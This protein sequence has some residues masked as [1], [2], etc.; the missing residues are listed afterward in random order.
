MD[1]SSSE[2]YSDEEVEAFTQCHLH[3]LLQG[4]QEVRVGSLLPR[5]TGCR[6]LLGESSAEVK[7]SEVTPVCDFDS[8]MHGRGTRHSA[9]ADTE[10]AADAADLT[11]S[12]QGSQG[13]DV[14]VT[15][16]TSMEEKNGSDEVTTKLK[17]DGSL[18]WTAIAYEEILRR[19]E[20]MSTDAKEVAREMPWQDCCHGSLSMTQTCHTLVVNDRSITNGKH[21]RCQY[22]STVKGI[23]TKMKKPS[24]A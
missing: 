2:V 24:S 7:D 18:L 8:P 20:D 11:Y 21:L 9:A 10:M 23:Q 1:R 6:F 14:R 3:D 19:A 4:T 22:C 17:G 5:P 16:R 15:Y 13:H 12:Q